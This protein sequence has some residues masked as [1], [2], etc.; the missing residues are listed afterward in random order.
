MWQ[1]NRRRRAFALYEVLLGLTIFVLGVLT[2]GWSVQNCLHASALSSEEDRVRQIL[3]NRMA[4]VQATPG[5]PDAKKET[6]VATG[7]GDVVLVQKSVPAGLKGEND[8]ELNG[9]NLV[10]LQAN[11]KRNGVVQSRKIEFYVY[12]QG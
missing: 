5:F 2:L 7:Y 10:T 8:T 12:R 11:W 4:E 3:A 6:K 9:I 1:D